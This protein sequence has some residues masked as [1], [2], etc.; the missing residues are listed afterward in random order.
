MTSL[1]KSLHSLVER[2]HN[3][4]TLYETLILNSESYVDFEIESLIQLLIFN[5]CVEAHE[6]M[7][8][9]LKL[10]SFV[11]DDEELKRLKH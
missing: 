5:V 3:L 11:H 2:M 8:A 9:L 7:Y 10:K 1:E 6:I 4:D